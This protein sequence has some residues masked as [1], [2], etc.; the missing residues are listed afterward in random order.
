VI[1]TAPDGSD[2]VTLEKGDKK[3]FDPPESGHVAYA[4]NGGRFFLTY[5]TDAAGTEAAR[6]QVGV[7]EQPQERA[8][9]K[10]SG[11]SRTGAGRS[12]STARATSKRTKRTSGKSSSSSAK[13]SG[14]K[15]KSKSSSS[16]KKG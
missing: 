3:T 13:S 11:G 2:S 5:E 10:K 1:L 7:S 15:A 4:P 9:Q 6:D 16:R 8:A 14:S 12:K